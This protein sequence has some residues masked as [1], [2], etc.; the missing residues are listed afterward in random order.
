MLIRVQA[1]RNSKENNRFRL[2]IYTCI[3]LSSDVRSRNGTLDK[4][5][6]ILFLVVSARDDALVLLI[7]TH[8]G[9]VIREKGFKKHKTSVR[10]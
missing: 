4:K 3:F 9:A 1:G 8:T 6:R 2:K 5:G 7:W 10:S